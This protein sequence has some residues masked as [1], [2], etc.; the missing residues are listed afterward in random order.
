MKKSLALCLL[1][2]L[3]CFDAYGQDE[4][5]SYG[6]PSDLKGLHKVFVDTGA[7]TKNRDT[8]IKGI[9]KAKLDF[10]IVDDAADAEIIL[11]FGAGKVTNK[12]VASVIG[13]GI[14]ARTHTSR[15]GTGVVIARARSKERLVH[16]FEDTQQSGWERKPVDNYVREFIK[17]YKKGND[18]K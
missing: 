9:L 14:V 8:I 3:A 13:T 15:T 7:D 11:G 10:E 18:L 2:L 6:Q 17:V 5:Y 4:S 16:S 1:I 12:A